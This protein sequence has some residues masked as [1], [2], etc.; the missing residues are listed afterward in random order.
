MDDKKE[1]TVFEL[2]LHETLVV[3]REEKLGDMEITRVP[4]GWVYSFDF[5]G[6]RSSPVVFVPLAEHNIISNNI[7][8]KKQGL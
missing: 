1:K 4:G 8:G 3:K 7:P 6:Y 5:P 2:R